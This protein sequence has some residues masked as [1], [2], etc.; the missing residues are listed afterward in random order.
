MSSTETTT[1]ATASVSAA[2]AA[3]A[4]VSAVSAAETFDGKTVVITG[5]SAGIGAGFARHAASLGMRLVLADIAADRLEALAGELKAG[6]AEVETVVVDV[7][8]P[9]S[10]EG[11]AEKAY[12]RFGSVDMLINNAGIMAMGYSWEIPAERWDAALRI[13]IGGYVNGLRAFVPRL[14]AQGTK[15]WVLNVS[16][17]DGMLPSPLM[18]PYSVTKFGTL[19]LSESLHYE[20]QMRQAPIQVSVVMP[21][22]VKSEIFRSA[23]PGGGTPPEIAAF[24]EQLQARA[25]E[26]GITPEEHARRV[27]DLVAGGAYWAVPQ[28]EMLDAVLQGR[29][30]MILSRTVPTLN[31][32]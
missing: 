31:L 21:D 5:A 18:A 23:K 14:L 2:T 7:A 32:G 25:D 3:S 12:A 16:S 1:A 19:A 6:G 29:T 10:V 20:M 11:L 15:A 13:N 30:D 9:A 27:F 26:Q 24:N 22:S 17:V 28:P 8:D 4:S